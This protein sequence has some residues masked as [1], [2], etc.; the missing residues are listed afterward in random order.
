MPPRT[1]DDGRLEQVCP[2]TAVN[3]ARVREYASG[4]HVD[5]DLAGADNW[6]GHLLNRERRIERIQ[7]IGSIVTIALEGRQASRK[8]ISPAS[9]FASNNRRCSDSGEAEELPE[10]I[11]PRHDGQHDAERNF[12]AADS[13]ASTSADDCTLKRATSPRWLG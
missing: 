6:G 12:T 5:D 2:L 11:V 7:N 9:C 10:R 1:G 4:N 13:A 8:R 3:L